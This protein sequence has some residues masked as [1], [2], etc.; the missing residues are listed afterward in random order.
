MGTGALSRCPN[1][2]PAPK[3]KN[4]YSPCASMAFYGEKFTIC[5]SVVG[6]LTHSISVKIV[7]REQYSTAPM[8]EYLYFFYFSISDI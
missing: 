7:K 2:S 6:L 1:H 3:L 8:F 5:T 4:K